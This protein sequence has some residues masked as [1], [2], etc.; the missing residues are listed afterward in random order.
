MK[1]WHIALQGCLKTGG[2]DYGCCPDTGGHIKYLLDLANSLE[3]DQPGLEQVIITRS[4]EDSKFPESHSQAKETL[5]KRIKLVRIEDSEKGY[6]PK[7][8]LWQHREKFIKNLELLLRN[9]A[10]KPDFIHAHYADAGAVAAELKRRYGIPFVFTGHSLGR[11]KE[12]E[13]PITTGSL[14]DFNARLTAE[15]EAILGAAL[16]I[17]SSKDEAENQYALYQNYRA[18]KI[19]IIAPGTS[20]VEVQDKEER[21]RTI[22]AKLEN[23]FKDRTKPLILAIARPMKRKNLGV[24]IDAFASRPWLRNHCNLLI[25]AGCRATLS[26]LQ[27]EQEAELV[28]LLRK[29]DD[30]DLHGYVALPKSHT[31]RDLE[32]YYKLAA[33]SSGIFVNPA[34]HEPFGLTLLEA[35]Y[36][37]LPC[38]STKNGGAADI[39]REN[40]NGLVIDPRSIEEL[41]GAMEEILS[42]SDAYLQFST[43][44]KNARR[45]LDWAVH[46]KRYQQVTREVVE[47]HL[48]GGNVFTPLEGGLI[49]SDIDNTFDGGCCRCACTHQLAREETRTSLRRVYGAEFR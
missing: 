28:G 21:R 25:L 48:S 1:I 14:E 40:G 10:E 35:T 31:E 2:I 20:F 45:N 36:C 23:F 32:V 30:Y 27:T 6:L 26:K 15:E 39:M 24:I 34:L 17:A 44:A 29:I 33:D 19:R 5:S 37:G 22:E 3:V 7:E 4:F 12:I 42:N 8:R 16:I 41:A 47:K 46:A 13:S 49:C 18:E 38:V 11:V 43:A 9:G